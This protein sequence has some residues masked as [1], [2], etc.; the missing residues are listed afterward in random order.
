MKILSRDLKPSVREIVRA[1]VFL[2]G[3]LVVAVEKTQFT[4]INCKIFY[5]KSD[6]CELIISS[7]FDLSMQGRPIIAHLLGT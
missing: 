6:Y 3:K 2:I 1:R 4:A 5:F 7:I